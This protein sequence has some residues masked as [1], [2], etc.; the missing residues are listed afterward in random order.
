MLSGLNIWQ[1]IYEYVDELFINIWKK[2]LMKKR[3]RPAD[4]D[5]R[6]NDHHK[7]PKSRWWTNVEDNKKRTLKTIHRA[8]HTIFVND[9]TIEKIQRILDMDWS[10]LQWDFVRDV[11]RI[12]ELYKWLEYHSHCKKDT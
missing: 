11:K 3:N 8:I 12:L 6:F 10:A 4:Y 1:H 2:I 9:T 5:S 7:V